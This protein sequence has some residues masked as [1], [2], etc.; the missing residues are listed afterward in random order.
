MGVAFR[1]LNCPPLFPRTLGA[2]VFDVDG[3]GSVVTKC[4]CTDSF[5]LIGV[6]VDRPEH[7]D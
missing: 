2:L 5:T 6:G 4:G 1:D 3:F 7:D